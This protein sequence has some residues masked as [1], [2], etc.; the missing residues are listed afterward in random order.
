LL[1]DVERTLVKL[2]QTLFFILSFGSMVRAAEGFDD[3][4]FVLPSTALQSA[5]DATFAVDSKGGGFVGSSFFYRREQS[6]IPGRYYFY[7]LTSGHVISKNCPVRSGQC[8]TIQ[9]TSGLSFSRVDGSTQRTSDRFL[10]LDK[11]EI[12]KLSEKPDLA[13]LRA[14]V[15]SSIYFSSLQPLSLS[16]SCSIPMDSKIYVIGFPGT[17]QR[18]NTK[19]TSV[20]N[21]YLSTK[22]WSI[23]VFVGQIEARGQ[24]DSS[25]SIFAGTTADSLSGNSGSP[26]VTADGQVFGVL[27]SSL[28]T[29]PFEN[30]YVGNDL[31]A[32]KK[33][34]SLLER[35]EVIKTFVSTP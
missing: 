23:G 1:I 9:L 35:C 25:S 5:W 27:D 2:T 32:P 12:V 33:A 14:T 18:S 16:P 20:A 17:Y 6:P 31:S 21:I 22:R 28:G 10:Q 11:I 34:H 26:A 3:R 29:G 8:N 15:D 4:K 13:L 7:F 30:I 19:C 24:N